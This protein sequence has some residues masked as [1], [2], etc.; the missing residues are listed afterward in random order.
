MKHNNL[1]IKFFLFFL[2][3]VNIPMFAGIDMQSHV[4]S[5]AGKA[6]YVLYRTKQSAYYTTGYHYVDLIGLTG[7]SLF[8]K[9]ND[10]MG[11]TNDILQSQY[12]YGALRYAYVNVD[13]DLNT[14]GQIISYYNGQSLSGTWDGAVTWNREHTWPQSKFKGSYS[15][16]TSIP[17]GYDMQSVRPASTSVNSDRGNTAYGETSSYYDP[18]EITISNTNYQAISKGSYRGDC[19]R[20]IL[21]DYINYGK[22]GGFYNALYDSNCNTD[23]LVQVGSNSNSVFQSLAI[24]LK[25]HME[26]PPSLTEMVRNDGGEVYQGNRNP[27]IDYPE[28]AIN[29]LRDQSG[30]TVYGVT[31]N[32]TA[33]IS[34]N[35]IYTTPTGFVTYLTYA[36][37]SHPASVTVTG[38]TYVYEPTLGRLTISAVTGA[39][40]ISTQNDP[41]AISNPVVDQVVTYTIDHLLYVSNLEEGCDLAVFDCAGRMLVQRT[42]CTSTETFQIGKGVYLLKIRVGNS[43][44]T[45]KVAHSF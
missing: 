35:Y 4:Q 42:N 15:S 3:C 40:L 41:D 14:S 39:V 34:P 9:L 27:F 32:T 19:A 13:K 17:I 38:G 1:I 6:A 2:F 25:W 31:T 45:Y 23:L 10:L 36:D 12:N 28:L 30:V 5:D 43:S 7:S 22:N 20:V 44:R 21:Y 8:D 33:T 16:G 29:L 37:G 24:L 26:D 18:N 11:S